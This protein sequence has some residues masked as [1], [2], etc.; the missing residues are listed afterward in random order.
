MESSGWSKVRAGSDDLV[1]RTDFMNDRFQIL[2]T[3]L[4]SVW[5]MSHSSQEILKSC[6]V[7]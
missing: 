1:I 6:E 2:L 4:A 5:L 3:D 7:S